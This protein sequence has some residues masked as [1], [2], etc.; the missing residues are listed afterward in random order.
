M[1]PLKTTLFLIAVLMVL[2]SCAQPPTQE[3]GAFAPGA[4][5]TSTP[6]SPTAPPRIYTDGDGP[7]GQQPQP[8]PKAGAG[9]PH[10]HRAA[11]H[12]PTARTQRGGLEELAGD[13]RRRF[14]EYDR[15]I[16][17]GA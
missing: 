17:A 2:V 4:A 15:A 7:G 6:V 12:Y 16:P 3:P 13:P 9:Y 14:R 1:K 8:N 10:R 11:Q 5:P